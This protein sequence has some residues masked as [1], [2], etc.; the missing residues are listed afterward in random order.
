MQRLR[1]RHLFVACEALFVVGCAASAA[2]AGLPLFGFGRILAGFATGLLL[3][4][5]LPPVIRQF[6]AG[7]LPTTVVWINLGF[8]GAVCVG[9]VLGGAVAAGHAWRWFFAALAGIGL[10]NLA[11]ALF[12]LP[13]QDP[14]NPKL[15]LD[16][17]AGVLGLPAV[18]L[19]FWASGELAAHGFASPRFGVPMGLGLACFVALLLFEYHQ[20]EPLSPVKR[21]WTTA[22]VVGTLVAM[23]AGGVFIAF[24]ELGERLQTEVAHRTPLQ[25]GLLFVPLAVTVCITAA[26]LGVLLRTRFL[27]FLVLGGMACLIGGGALIMTP[28]PQGAAVP[29][30]GAAALLGL[31]A[32][33]TVSP[34]LYLA[35]FPL[36]SKIIG[37]VFALVELVRS[38]ADYIIAPVIAKIAEVASRAPPLDWPG[39]HAAAAV[40]LWITGGFTLVGV[41]LWV[42]GGMGL[43]RPDIGAWI[44]RNQPA[45]RSTPLLARL[46]GLV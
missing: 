21:M 14:P 40:T 9:P 8:F 31:G 16:L 34:G 11:A 43:P 33:A 1:Q 3:V 28:G 10:L 25:T 30:L 37:R 15:P 13:L 26:L 35:G 17:W 38:L 24:L 27:P 32:G 7:K 36:Q 41:A 2:A 5:A 29:T 23:I 42:A 12:T 20:E 19:P 46:R 39:V 6:P 44:E 4:A 22:S 45:I 18:V